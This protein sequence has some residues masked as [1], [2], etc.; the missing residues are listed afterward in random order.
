M[1]LEEAINIIESFC[2][3]DLNP[4]IHKFKITPYAE[5]CEISFNR[6]SGSNIRY[7]LYDFMKQVKVKNYCTSSQY[8][9]IELYLGDII[10]FA[11]KLQLGAFS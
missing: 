10:K 4:R 3:K 2:L 11:R 5:F 7:I 9:F 1:T 8:E 6:V